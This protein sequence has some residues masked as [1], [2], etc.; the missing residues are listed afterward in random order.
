MAQVAVC[1]QVA[2]ASRSAREYSNAMWLSS[3]RIPQ[4]S[5]DIVR[6]I[7][8]SRSIETSAVHEVERDMESVLE[9]YVRD[10]REISEK[11][12]ALARSRNLSGT[13]VGRIK[14][15]LARERKIELGE[16][17]IDYLLDQMVE[18]L[19]MSGAVDE[20]Y[21]EDYELKRQMRD[22]LRKEYSAGDAVEAEVRTRMKHV[23]EGS[24]LWEVEYQRLREEVKRRR[25]M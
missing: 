13:E 6:T 24:S 21:A 11:A 9:Q 20:V 25:G 22:P 14:K 10:E 4:I 19:M 23:Q 16:D 2:I 17:A 5:R 3:A 1:A 8:G 7:V 12:S 18:M 15:D